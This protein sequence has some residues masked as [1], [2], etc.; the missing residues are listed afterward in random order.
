MLLHGPLL[1]SGVSSALPPAAGSWSLLWFCSG[2]W[3]EMGCADFT[4]L[5]IHWS[6]CCCL[7]VLGVVL[8]L[9]E[10]MENC[11]VLR[12]EGKVKSSH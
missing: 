11:P 2:R 1:C 4:S 10:L 8:L 9:Q 12:K 7:E 6:F 3:L 5:L